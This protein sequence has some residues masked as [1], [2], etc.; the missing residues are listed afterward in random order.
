MILPC[1]SACRG[2]SLGVSVSRVPSVLQARRSE[3]RSP[4]A[5]AG[6][7][8]GC[9]EG[10][11]PALGGAFVNLHCWKQSPTR[12]SEGGT[13]GAVEN[14]PGH[15]ERGVPGLR[16]WFVAE[17]ASGAGCRACAATVPGGRR[18]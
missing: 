1:L 17:G 9:P 3:L 15:P 14:L 18:A 11:R 7:T 12:L 5:G 16:G 10:V 2:R 6:D 13:L 4:E 8:E